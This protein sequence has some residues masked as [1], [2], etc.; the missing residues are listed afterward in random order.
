MVGEARPAPVDTL[1]RADDPP[2]SVSNW[3]CGYVF[4]LVNGP[5]YWNAVGWFALPFGHADAWYDRP[6]KSRSPFWYRS[7]KH[8]IA[9]EYAVVVTP[10]IITVRD[11][12][13]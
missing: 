7:A 10:L 5:A 1:H 13:W 3:I 2:M 12:C 6:S 11:P 9:S 8:W 4:P